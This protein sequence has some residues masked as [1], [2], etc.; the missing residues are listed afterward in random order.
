VSTIPPRGEPYGREDFIRDNPELFI[1]RARFFGHYSNDPVRFGL[2]LHTDMFREA[3]YLDDWKLIAEKYPPFPLEA[4]DLTRNDNADIPVRAHYLRKALT[5]LL[6]IIGAPGVMIEDVDRFFSGFRPGH[7]DK[8]ADAQQ[9]LLE[10][11]TAGV[12]EISKRS[13]LDRSTIHKLLKLGILIR[14]T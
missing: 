8:Y 11:E 3:F 7:A 10:N 6:Q 13:G 12:T 5:Q 1:E 2:L 4:D 14:P 9:V